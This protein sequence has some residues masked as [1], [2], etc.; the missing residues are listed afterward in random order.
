MRGPDRLAIEQVVLDAPAPEEV[1]VRTAAAGICHSDLNY[2]RGRFPIRTPTVLGHESAGVVEAVGSGVVGFEPG[3]RVATCLSAFCGQCEYCLSGR[4]SLCDQVGLGRARGEAPRLTLEGKRCGQFAGLGSF[5]EA[6]LVH[7]HAVV[8]VPDRLPLDCAALLGCAVLTGVGAVTRTARVK[9]GST[10]AVIG[11]GGV[12]LNCVQGAVLAGAR[13]VIAIDIDIEKLPLAASFGATDL[14]DASTVDPVARVHELLP[15]GGHGVSA[16]PGG[17]DYAFEAIGRKS[18][19]EQSFAM[20]RK[21]GTST[22]VG[23]LSPGET[24]ELPAEAFQEEKRIQGSRMGSNRFRI[25]I[26]RLAEL[27]LSERLKL[28][29]L[30]SA[31]ISLDELEQGFIALEEGKVARSVV[32]FN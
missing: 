24:I 2:L 26:P 5:A 7:K 16:R 11:C 1:L 8:E 21:G 4:P 13:R 30:I 20:L 29:E 3:D 27:Y 18:A 22:L 10:V 23:F 12:G 9:P 6:M 14:I 25:D 15:G 28:H 32:C 31:R 19:A 17:V